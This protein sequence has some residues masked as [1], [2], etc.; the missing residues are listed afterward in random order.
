VDGAF[1]I[2]ARIA[3]LVFVVACMAAAGLGLGL[4]DVVVSLRRGRLVALALIENFGVAPAVAWVLA[5]A[6][7]L[8]P[9][10]ATGLVLL[11]IAAGAPFLPKLAE[12]ARGDAAF[13]IGLMLLLTVG[14][15]AVLPVA[16]PLLTPGLS[17][18]PWTILRPILVTM[19]VPLAAGML[20]RANSRQR[21]NWLRPAVGAV[22]NVA[23]VAAV[24]LLIGL[25]LGAMLD[26]FGSGAVL[27]AIVFVASMVT[28]GYG[29]G[30]PAPTTRSVLGLGT[31]QR[32]IA[33]ALI[34]AGSAADP[35]VVVTV[36]LA[37]IAGLFVLVP[38]ARL[39]GRPVPRPV[40]GAVPLEVTR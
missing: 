20:V 26:T 24:V 10:Y 18:D 5:R 7:G 3:V 30:G 17:A 23:M 37:T 19:L 16:L 13:S 6:F 9:P 27:A 34:L 36:L 14:T 11:G 22:S 31:G 21:A 12:I 35:R 28:I 15:A 38:A 4:R 29:L 40:A 8:E 2:V 25:N 32:N 39:M 1:E 33:A